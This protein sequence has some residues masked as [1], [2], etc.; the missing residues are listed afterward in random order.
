MTNAAPLFAI[1]NVILGLVIAVLSLARVRGA[2]GVT[3]LER[4]LVAAVAGCIAGAYALYLVGM[5]PLPVHPGIPTILLVF[6]AGFIA[7]A[8]AR[9]I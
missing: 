6:L 3:F 8:L 1:L 4:L 9:G 5:I 7:R 2:T